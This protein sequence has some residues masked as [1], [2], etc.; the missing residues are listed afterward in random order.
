VAS[1]LQAVFDRLK[2]L[3]EAYSDRCVVMKDEASAYIL[4][5]HEVREKDG[6]R[7]WFGGVETKKSYVSVHLM[8]VYVHPDLL[9]QADPLLLKRMQ[10]KSCFNF[11]N[12]DDDLLRSLASLIERSADRFEADGRIFLKNR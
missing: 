9:Q 12:V 7:T 5:T 6:Y 8:P 11:K 10:G 2:P 4:G 1:D 3:F